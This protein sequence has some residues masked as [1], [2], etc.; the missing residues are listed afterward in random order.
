[1]DPDRTITTADVLYVNRLANEG[2]ENGARG[3]KQAGDNIRPNA[4]GIAAFAPHDGATWK[5]THTNRELRNWTHRSIV[6]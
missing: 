5:R 6:E 3:K 1:M 2:G 4:E